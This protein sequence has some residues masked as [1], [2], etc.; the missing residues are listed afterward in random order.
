M[1]AAT[2]AFLS[3]AG[4]E[5]RMQILFRRGQKGQDQEYR[6]RRQILRSGRRLNHLECS[7]ELGDDWVIGRR[8]LTSN[9]QPLFCLQLRHCLAAPRLYCRLHSQT[10]VFSRQTRVF[11][12]QTCVFSLVNCKYSCIYRRV[13]I[14]QYQTVA[15]GTG[16]A[17]WLKTIG[18]FFAWLTQTVGKGLEGFLPDSSPYSQCLPE[19]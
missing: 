7:S 3:A 8:F 13:F 12:L 4:V 6:T 2:T 18:L 1:S 11:S 19:Q 9:C 15:Q 10:C 14:S 5:P 17:G 16:R